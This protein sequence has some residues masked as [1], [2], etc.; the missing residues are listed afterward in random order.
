MTMLPNAVQ[1]INNPRE[2]ALGYHISAG[3]AWLLYGRAALLDSPLVYAALEYRCAIERLVLEYWGCISDFAPDPDDVERLDAHKLH[4]KLLEYVSE[5]QD[6]KRERMRKLKRIMRFN[7]VMGEETGA[8]KPVSEP[9]FDELMRYWADLSRYCHSFKSP[10]SSWNSRHFVVESYRKLGEVHD[11]LVNLCVKQ[12]LGGAP[13]EKMP[14][15]M[16]AL[17]QRFIDEL[18]DEDTV[19]VSMTLMDPVLYQ[20]NRNEM[21]GQP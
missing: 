5:K 11:H 13:V 21:P 1:V 10:D 6:P 20:R 8:D 19:R 17:R 15:E 12:Y 16:R 2:V 3:H 7:K 4:L 18:I 9:D 14:P